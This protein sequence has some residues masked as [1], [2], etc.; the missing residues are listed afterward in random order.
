MKM[1]RVLTGFCALF[2]L[3]SG[4]SALGLANR[5][6]VSARSGNNANSCDN[7]N[8]P[9][10]T[11]AGAVTQLNPDGECIVLDSGGYGAVTTRR[12]SPS[13]LRRA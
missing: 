2:C 12:A 8:T 9:C 5:V 10:Q 6:F 13:K 3:L 1:S 4:S 7:I 11:F